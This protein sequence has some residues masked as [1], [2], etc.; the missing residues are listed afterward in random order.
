MTPDDAMDRAY[1]DFQREKKVKVSL[2]EFSQYGIGKAHL[3]WIFRRAR[4]HLRG[5][6]E[7]KVGV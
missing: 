1:R 3:L 4:K 2:R 6:G 5:S 7:R